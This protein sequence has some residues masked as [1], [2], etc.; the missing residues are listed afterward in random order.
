MAGGSTA[1]SNMP[2]QHPVMSLS[3]SCSHHVGLAIQLQ[4][5]TLP[6]EDRNLLPPNGDALPQV[7]RRAKHLGLARH[8]LRTKQGC[9]RS[10][11]PWSRR[12]GAWRP[13][14]GTR[15][16]R[17]AQPRGR[18]V[19][20][21]HMPLWKARFS[22]CL[23]QCNNRARHSSVSRAPL[24]HFD[25]RP[26][27]PFARYDVAAAAAPYL[28]VHLLAPIH[29]HAH[30]M[31]LQQ[32]EQQDLGAGVFSP[33]ACPR[34]QLLPPLPPLTGS[35]FSF[36]VPPPS[37]AAIA[38]LPLAAAIQECAVGRQALGGRRGVPS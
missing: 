4:G 1:A 24:L 30:L 15:A 21:P 18:R 19:A 14:G 34:L 32:K 2:A 10:V 35:K 37:A 22:S 26:G 12:K 33:A 13:R 28:Q 17:G 23:Q 3:C 20:L 9:K 38:F 6:A 7:Q 36:C 27:R 16:G 8:Q 11:L 31:L 29:L 25:A 5:A